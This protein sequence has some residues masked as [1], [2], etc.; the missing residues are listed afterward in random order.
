M[1]MDNPR[2]HAE[3]EAAQRA[4]EAELRQYWFERAQQAVQAAKEEARADE[5]ELAAISKQLV[6]ESYAAAVEQEEAAARYYDCVQTQTPHV[7][8]PPCATCGHP[9]LAHTGSDA[10]GYY[11]CDWYGCPCDDWQAPTEGA[12]EG[13]A[14]RW[15]INRGLPPMAGGSDEAITI[16]GCS[17]LVDG[18][19]MNL[20]PGHPAYGTCRC[21]CHAPPMAG[22]APTP[23]DDPTGPGATQEGT[24]ALR[25]IYRDVAI[26]EDELGE[27]RFAE[28]G[29]DGVLSKL[30]AIIGQDAEHTH[31]CPTCHHDRSCTCATF[32]PSEPLECATCSNCRGW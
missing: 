29:L 3:R 21:A 13:D 25:D 1:S 23:A 15:L 19:C 4:D 24:K 20:W 5:A 18:S 17:R 28:L 6:A 26:L 32:V 8:Q 2:T 27:D 7:D 22:G 9:A 31:P 30:D 11:P 16:C 10:K 12:P 14:A